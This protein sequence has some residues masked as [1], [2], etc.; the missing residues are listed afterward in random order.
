ML[1]LL[2]TANTTLVEVDPGA[3]RLHSLHKMLVVDLHARNVGNETPEDL[4]MERVPF[5]LTAALF[6]LACGR[7]LYSA[8]LR[9]HGLHSRPR[10]E[11]QLK[12]RMQQPAEAA[13][14]TVA[15]IV[16]RRFFEPVFSVRLRGRRVGRHTCCASQFVH[17]RGLDC[18][19]VENRFEPARRP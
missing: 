5:C 4:E 18:A 1:R 16:E 8:R 3:E 19:G 14:E 11:E 7:G 17:Q 12:Q 10:L 15:R 13:Y 2:E 9:V 6:L